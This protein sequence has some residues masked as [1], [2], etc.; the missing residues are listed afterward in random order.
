MRFTLA[1]IALVSLAT[2]LTLVKDDGTTLV[3][4]NKPQLIDFDATVLP[5][6][7][8]E[9]NSTSIADAD[10]LSASGGGPIW[11]K[12][13]GKA[14]QAQSNTVINRWVSAAGQKAGETY[15]THT[16]F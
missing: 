11:M 9:A 16:E 14:P 8:E 5:V 15:H 13:M 3:L 1:S 4:S 6:K 2:C 12:R 7:T 10:G